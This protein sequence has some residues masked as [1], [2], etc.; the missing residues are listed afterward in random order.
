M[1]KVIIASV[2][3][4]VGLC[5]VS[6]F[7][8]TAAKTALRVVKWE[9][10]TLITKDANTGAEVKQE[11][12]YPVFDPSEIQAADKSGIHAM[13]DNGLCWQVCKEQ[14]GGYGICHTVC[15]THCAG[16]GGEG[17]PRRR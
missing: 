9:S 7:G 15:W 5:L 16:Q 6:M 13:G 12:K 11:F 17:D 2:G 10:G 8:Q 14:C 3:I 1:K 4:S